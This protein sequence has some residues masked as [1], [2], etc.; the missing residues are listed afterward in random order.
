MNT[1]LADTTRLQAASRTSATNRIATFW[2]WISRR[3]GSGTQTETR[4]H[5]RKTQLPLLV[6]YNPYCIAA[7]AVTGPWI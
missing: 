4:R 2:H 7:K 5:S 6:A 3:H 1:Y